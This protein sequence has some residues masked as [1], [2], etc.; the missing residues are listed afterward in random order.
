MFSLIFF[1]TLINFKEV[2]KVSTHSLNGNILFNLESNQGLIDLPALNAEFHLT[3][4][5]RTILIKTVGYKYLSWLLLF[6]L[7]VSGCWFILGFPRMRRLLTTRWHF[8]STEMNP[9]AW[10]YISKPFAC[11]RFILGCSWWLPTQFIL[12]M[13][14]FHP[15]V[16]KISRYTM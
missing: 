2:A 12:N 13:P 8:V 10:N 14:S 1:Y 3:F 11:T 15:N 5:V 16:L 4:N 6:D 7:V 9:Y